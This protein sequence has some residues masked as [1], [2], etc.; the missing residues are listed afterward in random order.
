MAPRPRNEISVAARARGELGKPSGRRSTALAFKRPPW[1]A[2]IGFLAGA[3]ATPVACGSSSNSE[4]HDSG[5]VPVPSVN[6]S[7]GSGRSTT[8]GSGSLGTGVSLG[9]GPTGSSTGSTGSSGSSGAPPVCDDA[10][11]CTCADGNTTTITG[12]VYDPA[13]KNPLYNV[14][15]YVP[16]PNSPLPNLDTVPLSCGCSQLFP[17]MVL[18]TGLPTDATGRFE[19]PCAPSGTVSLVV[20]TGKWR[21]RYDGIP[22]IANQTNMVPN[23]R[24]PTSTAEGSLPNIAISTGGSDSLECLPLR[25]GVA[26]SEYV[27]GSAAGGHIHIY[28]GYRGA[29]MA[30]GAVESYQSLWDQQSDLNAHDVVLLS[31]EGHETTGGNPG[32][33]MTP[34]T[35]TFLMDYANA[36]GRVFASH[37]HYAWFNTGPFATG[38]SA[39]ATWTPG[40]QTIDDTQSF[41]GDVDTTLPSGAT[42]PEGAALQQWLGLVGALTANQLPIWFARQNVQALMAPPSTEWIH[43]D[44][45]VTAAPNATQYFSVDTPV[46]ASPSGVCGR[47][48]YSDLHVSGGPGTNAAGVAADYPMAGGGGRRGG[49]AQTNIVPTQCAMHPLTPQEEAL[50]FMLFDLSSCLV[51]IGQTTVPPPTGIP[52]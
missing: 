47:V 3:A 48:V 42:F 11:H 13:N 28:T 9:M 23:M 20:Q 24:L 15:V 27:A 46:G 51:P 34:A 10:G 29:A 18:A 17:A 31:C 1:I 8:G 2:T 12:Y 21:M 40:G 7:N 39:V 37:Y 6:S 19:I 45:S 43:L 4:F 22:I 36:G 35:Q 25:I 30:M 50:E 52:R 44:K 38:A 14:S 49:A 41:P 33:P 26:A 5:R 16:S 32:A